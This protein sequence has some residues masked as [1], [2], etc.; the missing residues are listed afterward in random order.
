MQFFASKPAQ[1]Y[2]LTRFVLLRWLGL[3]YLVAFFAA[4]RQLVPLVGANGLTPAS[5]FIHQLRQ[6]LGSSWS[7]FTVLPMYFWFDYS[8][9]SLSVLP[10]IGVVLACFRRRRVRQFDYARRHVVSLHVDRPCGTGMVRLRLGNPAA[11]N[12]LSRHFPLSRCSMRALSRAGA[13]P[14]PV[15][16]LFRWLIFRIML[17]S[18]LIKLRGDSCWRD[19]TAL[20]YFISR[21]SRFRIRAAAGSISCLT[22]FCRP[23]R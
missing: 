21:R 10:W 4:A 20:Y 19:L 9:T 18:A 23:A 17:G 13:A 7:G 11:G 2:W 12:R 6:Q 14:L 8:D 22:P 15:I 3:V 16:F 5:L 1:T